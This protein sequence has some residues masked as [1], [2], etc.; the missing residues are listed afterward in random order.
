ML[1]HEYRATEDAIR[2]LQERLKSLSQNDKLK[3]EMEFEEKLRQ[4]M[5]EHQKSLRD[6]IALLD[7]AA[8]GKRTVA[9]KDPAR[10]RRTR[11]VKRY[12]NPHN[13]EVVDTKGGNHRT[14]K[15]WKAQ[16]GSDEVETWA[17]LLS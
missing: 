7:P 3:K 11:K 17:T 13:G 9:A 8:Y 2:E 1:I 10:P 5:G 12:K 15:D 16:W 4:L 14:L 6:I